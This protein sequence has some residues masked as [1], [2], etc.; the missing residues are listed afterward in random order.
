MI[1]WIIPYT[2]SDP[3]TDRYFAKAL[4]KGEQISEYQHTRICL[5]SVLH[6]LGEP[7]KL[8]IETT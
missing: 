7:L 6:P 4:Q 8:E 2:K 3:Y 5:K 1:M